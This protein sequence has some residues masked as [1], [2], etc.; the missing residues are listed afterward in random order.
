MTTYFVDQTF[1]I[2][3]SVAISFSFLLSTRF[4]YRYG[5]KFVVSVFFWCC[6]LFI[7]NR[8]NI[9]FTQAY[10]W[11]V[12][13]ALT[14]N[15]T[16]ISVRFMFSSTWPAALSHCRKISYDPETY[17]ATTLNAKMC[18]FSA[19][20]HTETSA[21]IGASTNSRRSLEFSRRDKITKC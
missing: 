20:N 15:I 5:A 1:N 19:D 7:T 21:W 16:L 2:V 18:S 6:Y 10:S 17:S 11:A 13:K 14:V 3:H 8:R 4:W 12:I 9:S